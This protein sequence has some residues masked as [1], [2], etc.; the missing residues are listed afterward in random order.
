MSTTPNAEATMVLHEL[1]A[2]VKATLGSSLLGLYLYGS[3][4]AGDFDPDI[5]DIDLLAVLAADLTDEQFRALDLMHTEF[6]RAHLV[7]DDRL[8][9]AYISAA[10]LRDFGTRTTTLG[11]ISPGEPFHVIEADPGWLMNWYV[12]QERGRTLFG[13]PPAT[14]IR[15][16][17][18]DEFV[19][20][21]RRQ[22][23]N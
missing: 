11:I 23:R 15:P 8:D 4:V 3:L 16:I 2:D 10:A 19:R 12:V 7:W 17:S 6:V 5:S 13:P 1:T 18:K 21:V 22:A 20:T 14:F 9:I